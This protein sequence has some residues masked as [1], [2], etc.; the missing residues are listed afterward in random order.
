MQFTYFTFQT[1]SLREHYET[2][3]KQGK[4]K[5]EFSAVKVTGS[6]LLSLTENDFYTKVEDIH[7][8]VGITLEDDSMVL[9][10]EG[11]QI[12]LLYKNIEKVYVGE[13]LLRLKHQ[14]SEY[15]IWL[16][17]SDEADVIN[18]LFLETDCYSEL[19]VA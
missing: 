13:G 2:L 14:N 8:P 18:N 11:K 4:T 17:D 6:Q 3:H 1:C 7:N 16:D 9:C 19:R 5:G 12:T 15:T 10:Y